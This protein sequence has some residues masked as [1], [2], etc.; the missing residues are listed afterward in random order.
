[1]DT[2]L[3]HFKT[4]FK[5]LGWEKHC[6]LD[7]WDF[8]EEIPI[9]PG[10]MF[11]NGKPVKQ[12]SVKKEITKSFDVVCDC[13]VTDLLTGKCDKSLLCNF[14]I[15]EDGVVTQQFEINIYPDE[16]EF[17]DNLANKFFRLK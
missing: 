11:I 13:S 9:N 2:L 14:T 12:D 8:S 4:K 17:F 3:N 5:E 10:A 6:D 16:I 15:A 1:M 7:Y